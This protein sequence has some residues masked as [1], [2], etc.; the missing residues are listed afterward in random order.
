MS[1]E[2]STPA[3]GTAGHTPAANTGTAVPDL[4]LRDSQRKMARCAQDLA[5]PP[6]DDPEDPR[7]REEEEAGKSHLWGMIAAGH[8]VPRLPAAS[9]AETTSPRGSPSV[10]LEQVALWLAEEEENTA[11][12]GREH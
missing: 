1:E 6:D 3:M 10:R 11:T 12:V 4:E 8:R 7:K 5:M 2:K 9:E